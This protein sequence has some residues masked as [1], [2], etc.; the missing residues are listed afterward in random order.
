MVEA[1][2]GP[3]RA[4]IVGYS[5]DASRADLEIFDLGNLPSNR[6]VFPGNGRMVGDALG[7]NRSKALIIAKRLR[8]VATRNPNI[9]RS[10][11]LS[12]L[13]LTRIFCTK[14]CGTPA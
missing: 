10:V 6:L 5:I 8:W 1:G 12:P 2:L 7:P 11:R 9:F 13:K 4:Y 3:V 14:G